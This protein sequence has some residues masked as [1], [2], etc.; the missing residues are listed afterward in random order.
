MF[1]HIIFKGCSAYPQVLDKAI[2]EK[3]DYGSAKFKKIYNLRSGSE[4]MFSRLL[5]L[6][7]RNPSVRGLQAV[8]NHCTIAHITVLLIDFTGARTGNRD[9]LRFVKSFLPNI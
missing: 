6:C 3:I 8:S 4:G 2:Q 9:K 5:I 1:C 7:M